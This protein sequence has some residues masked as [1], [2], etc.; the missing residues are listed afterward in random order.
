MFALRYLRANGH[1][2][3]IVSKCVFYRGRPARLTGMD[4]SSPFMKSPKKGS[5]SVRIQLEHITY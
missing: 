4:W 5:Y 2:F 3:E 1:S